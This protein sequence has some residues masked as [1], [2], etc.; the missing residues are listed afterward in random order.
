MTRFEHEAS[1]LSRVSAPY[2]PVLHSKNTLEDGHAF[3]AMERLIDRS[4]ADELADWERPPPPALLAS[5]K[6]AL[7]ESA[8]ALHAKGVLHRD[9][10]PENV[11]LAN[12]ERL[13]AKLMDFGLART[14][15]KLADER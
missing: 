12:E 9:L 2:V 14:A 5:V 10:K 6:N 8:A 1:T 11:F 15:E 7:L 13:V 3:V 4:L